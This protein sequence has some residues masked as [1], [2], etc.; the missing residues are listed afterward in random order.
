MRINIEQ[1]EALEI[2]E[3]SRFHIGKLEVFTGDD[4]QQESECYIVESKKE[5][6]VLSK[7]IEPLRVGS[8]YRIRNE[9]G[10]RIFLKSEDGPSFIIQLCHHKG[11]VFLDVEQKP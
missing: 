9:P 7:R 5:S 4:D 8:G 2:N 3:F 10:V 11:N 6:L 1:R